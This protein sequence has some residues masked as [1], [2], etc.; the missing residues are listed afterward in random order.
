MP[1]IFR[2]RFVYLLVCVI[3][4]VYVPLS[5]FVI[6][7]LSSVNGNCR[8][9]NNLPPTNKREYI[10]HGTLLHGTI[11][12]KISALYSSNALITPV[13]NVLQSISISV[14]HTYCIPDGNGSKHGKK[15]IITPNAP[16]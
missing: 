3:I 4:S 7:S 8:F 11:P 15:R 13:L 6:N 12:T 14:D 10:D 1:V 9:V 5:K 16:S 2:C